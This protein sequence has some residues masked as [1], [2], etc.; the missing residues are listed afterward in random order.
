MI[1]WKSLSLIIAWNEHISE[2]T[3]FKQQC[4]HCDVPQKYVKNPNL[5]GQARHQRSLYR[6]LNNDKEVLN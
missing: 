4:G 1:F 6:L 5:G 3:E 2:L